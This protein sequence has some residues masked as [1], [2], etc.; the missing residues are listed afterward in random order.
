MLPALTN[1]THTYARQIQLFIYKQH[2]ILTLAVC[3]D[4]IVALILP[5]LPD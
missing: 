1:I 3:L 4:L 5:Y 2:V